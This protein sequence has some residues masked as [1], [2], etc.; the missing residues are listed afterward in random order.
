MNT[1]QMRHSAAGEPTVMQPEA[2]S[3]MVARQGAGMDGKTQVSARIALEILE[4]VERLDHASDMVGRLDG[5]HIH[6]DDWED[7]G[8]PWLTRNSG[9]GSDARGCTPKVSQCARRS[10]D[11]VQTRPGHRTGEAGAQ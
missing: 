2:E 9:D 10:P 4:A 5:A 3:V 8:L 6:N 11:L 7:E 1:A